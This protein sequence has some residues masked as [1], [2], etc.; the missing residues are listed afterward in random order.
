MC[1]SLKGLT[2]RIFRT[3]HRGEPIRNKSDCDVLTGITLSKVALPSRRRKQLPQRY[4]D[5]FS[6][7]LFLIYSAMNAFDISLY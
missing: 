5:N 7:V 2:G 4:Q 6:S 1:S 3:F